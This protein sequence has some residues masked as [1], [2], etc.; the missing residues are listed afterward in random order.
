MKAQEQIKRN[1][2]KPTGE[3][4]S[5]LPVTD[6]AA[7]KTSGGGPG[8]EGPEESVSFN[9]GKGYFDYTRK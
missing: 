8:D 2:T 7:M 9:Y 6:E 3:C 1:E 5:D 4:L